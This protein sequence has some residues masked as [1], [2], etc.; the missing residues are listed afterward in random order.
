MHIGIVND[1]DDTTK[2]LAAKEYESSYY[3]KLIPIFKTIASSVIS[4]ATEPSRALVVG[5]GTGCLA[6]EFSKLFDEVPH[7]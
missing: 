6:F 4:N 5:C 1:T 3:D 7:P 2:D